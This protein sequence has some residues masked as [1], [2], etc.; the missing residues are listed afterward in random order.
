MHRFTVSLK[1][2][3]SSL[4]T[5]YIVIELAAGES[6]EYLLEYLYNNSLS[7]LR[8]TAGII[9]RPSV[10]YQIRPADLEARLKQAGPKFSPDPLYF[11]DAI[12][13]QGIALFDRF[14]GTE[15][16]L[17]HSS[18]HKHHI[19][20]D[21]NTPDYSAGSELSE[22][23]TNELLEAIRS[24]E[25]DFLVEQGQCK[26]PPLTGQLYQIPSGRFVRSF[27][28]VGSLQTSRSAMD[29]IFFW[30]IPYLTNCV[31]IITDTWS[32]SSISQTIS[33]R[34]IDYSG[35][36]GFPCPIEMLGEYHAQKEAYGKAAIIIIERFLS[37]LGSDIPENA[38][39]LILMSATHTG[40]LASIIESRIAASHISPHQVQFVSLFKL[41]TDSNV[42]TLRDYSNTLDF[43]PVDE[44]I[45]QNARDTAI[46]IDGTAYFPTTNI[47]VEIYRT[48]QAIRPYSEFARRYHKIPFAR[49]HVTDKTSDQTRP[50]HHAVWLDTKKIID[51]P[52]FQERLFEKLGELRPPPEVIIIPNH[53]SAQLLA[54]ITEAYFLSH[55]HKIEICCHNDLLL[56]A[57]LVPGDASLK[58]K[59]EGLSVQSAILILDDVF[60]TGVRVAAYQKNLRRIG[61]RGSFQYIAAIARPPDEMLWNENE[62]S[63]LRARGN[64]SIDQQ[65]SPASNQF[66]CVEMLIL[67][68]W[69]E[70]ECPWCSEHHTATQH[71]EFSIGRDIH[72][73]EHEAGLVNDLFILPPDTQEDEC[74]LQTGSF[75]GP[76]GMA[77]SN[78]FCLVAG[79][80]Q[81]LRTKRFSDAPLLGSKHYLVSVV[82]GEKVYRAHYTDSVL[83]ASL[84]RSLKPYEFTYRDRKKEKSRT[85]RLWSSLSVPTNAALL[86]E[87]VLAHL[88]NKLPELDLADENKVARL[89]AAG[90]LTKS[91]PGS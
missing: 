8:T 20:K 27:L 42:L 86:C 58:A 3:A 39:V 84:M 82:L 4:S 2:P 26:L 10:K 35:Q 71:P 21:L 79:L 49:V 66:D 25:M 64:A 63:F 85:T 55:E 91:A 54:E 45:S 7:E 68:H 36:P 77:E 69:A 40:S 51:H 12:R 80:V 90:I 18:E 37:R 5:R 47:D 60:I 16:R 19:S 38:K 22:M 73:L 32:I 9:I 61:F 83:T 75:F 52:A 46:E 24:A 88:Q 43:R 41:G 57:D 44:D 89:E 13:G 76:E 23:D 59:L 30:L 48:R 14:D 31:G 17:L 67:P 11:V 15:I 62:N 34:L 74:I 70:D 33:R 81:T 53:S 1:N 78:T 50:R 6:I 87:V 28:R 72:A 56:M 29:A 65:G